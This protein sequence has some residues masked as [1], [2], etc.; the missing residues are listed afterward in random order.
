MRVALLAIAGIIA[1]EGCAKTRAASTPAPIENTNPAQISIEGS[2]HIVFDPHER[3]FLIQDSTL[4]SIELLFPNDSS[5]SRISL[6]SFDRHR[7]I[8]TGILDTMRRSLFRAS[9]IEL[10]VTR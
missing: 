8:V 5:T 6:L 9:H 1:A 4:T 7:V 2:F 10:A 3:Y